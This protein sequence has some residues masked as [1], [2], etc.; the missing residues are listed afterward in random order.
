MCVCVFVSLYV[1]VGACA[2]ADRGRG[3]RPPLNFS[4]TY[5]RYVYIIVC[6]TRQSMLAPPLFQNPGSATA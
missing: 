1:S 6:I 5:R 4:N 3:A 2:V